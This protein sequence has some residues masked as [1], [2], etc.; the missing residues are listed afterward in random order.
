MH[1]IHVC[2]YIYVI[3]GLHT[4]DRLRTSTHTPT[5]LL[6]HSCAVHGVHALAAARELGL[7]PPAGIKPPAADSASPPVRSALAAAAGHRRSHAGSAGDAAYAAL[8]LRADPHAGPEHGLAA[9]L[10]GEAMD[11]TNTLMVTTERKVGSDA[12]VRARVRACMCV[13]VFR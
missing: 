10:V 6:A 12:R 3:I 11:T 7:H 8:S 2:S 4:Y 9:L 13:Y 1:N 5:R